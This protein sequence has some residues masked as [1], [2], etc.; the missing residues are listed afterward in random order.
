VLIGRNGVYTGWVNKTDIDG[1]A[2]GTTSLKKSGVVKV[3]ELGEELILRAKNGRLDYMEKGTGIIPADLTSNLMGWGK[4]DPSIML[5]QN[6]PQIGVHPEFH[7]T[8]IQIDNSIGELI[9]IDKCDQNTLPDVEKIVN[10]AL[11][12]HTQKLNQSLRK[13][14]R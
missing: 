14:T 7:N 10:K 3:D 9:H 5:D 4:L 13:F 11:E 1:F 6:R 12:Q 2:T 8:Q